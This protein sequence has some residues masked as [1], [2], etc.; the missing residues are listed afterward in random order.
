MQRLLKVRDS[1]AIAILPFGPYAP[2]GGM[3]PGLTSEADKHASAGAPNLPKPTADYDPD[4]IVISPGDKETYQTRTTL[5]EKVNAD[6]PHI[7]VINPTVNFN[8]QHRLAS[9]TA[10]I[11]MDN[12]NLPAEKSKDA[13]PY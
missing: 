11:R 7:I 5:P 8:G 1:D 4:V 6:V 10:S 9:H 2:S 3:G 13:V 12:N